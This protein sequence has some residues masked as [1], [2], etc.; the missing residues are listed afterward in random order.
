MYGT[1]APVPVPVTCYFRI[2]HSYI[3]STV[4]VRIFCIVFSC[5]G[6]GIIAENEVRYRV[7]EFLPMLCP[8]YK[9]SIYALCPKSLSFDRFPYVLKG[10]CLS[11]K[12]HVGPGL[13]CLDLFINQ[14]MLLWIVSWFMDLYSAVKVPVEMLPEI[15]GL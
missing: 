6:I 10:T 3:S 11:L 8:M 4:L 9:Y 2:I 7:P 1:I 14:C 5:K 13:G 12:I 15:V